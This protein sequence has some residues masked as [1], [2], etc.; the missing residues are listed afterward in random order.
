MFL[1]MKNSVKV[2][3]R[4]D[5]VFKKKLSFAEPLPIIWAMNV[6]IPSFIICVSKVDFNSSEFK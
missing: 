4:A 2:S 5:L 6:I 1:V 3:C